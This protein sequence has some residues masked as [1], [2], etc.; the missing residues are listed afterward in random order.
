MRVQQQHQQQQQQQ[1]QQ[2]SKNNNH[3]NNNTDN[4]H[5]KTGCSYLLD[6]PSTCMFQALDTRPLRLP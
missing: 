2:Q 5:F 3:K 4:N 6:C 1:Q